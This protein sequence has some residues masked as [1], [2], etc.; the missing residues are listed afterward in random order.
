MFLDP[1][2]SFDA[3]GRDE[4]NDALLRWGHKMGPHNRP[5]TGVARFHGLRH[6]GKLVAVTAGDALL[7][8]EVAGLNRSQAWELARVCAARPD[9]C[10]VIVRLWRE[11][12]FPSTSIARGYSWAVSYQDAA[13]HSGGL[14]RFDGWISLAVSRSGTDQRSGR[15]G[16]SKVIWGWHPDEAVRLSAALRPTH[17][18]AARRGPPSRQAGG[19]A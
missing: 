10:R 19:M 16:R 11:F 2:I 8:R 13:L 17:P 6:T 1:L 5:D 18:D 4:C 14:Y 7:A 3:I 12:V 9:L 15:K